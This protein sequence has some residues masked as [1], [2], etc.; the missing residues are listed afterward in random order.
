MGAMIIWPAIGQSVNFVLGVLAGRLPRIFLA[1][2]GWKFIKSTGWGAYLE[3][4]YRR[5][6]AYRVLYIPLP[7]WRVP[8]CYLAIESCAGE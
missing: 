6:V 2:A 3:R 5:P 7:L 4:E 1:G 8:I